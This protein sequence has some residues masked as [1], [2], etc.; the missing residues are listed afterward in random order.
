MIWLKLEDPFF[1]FNI[2][3]PAKL[4]YIDKHIIIEYPTIIYAF[5]YNFNTFALIISKSIQ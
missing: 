5:E 4:F 1:K 2:E 3:D